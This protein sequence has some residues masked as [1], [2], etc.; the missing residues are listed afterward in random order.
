MNDSILVA[1]EKRFEYITK[2]SI[3]YPSIIVLKANTP[4]DN[5]NRYSSFFLIKQFNQIIEKKFKYDF[6][7]LKKGF[8]GPYYVYGFSN[9]LSRESKLTLLILKI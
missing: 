3:T 5:K 2:L 4:G 8:D 7:T 9:I 6:K 1:R